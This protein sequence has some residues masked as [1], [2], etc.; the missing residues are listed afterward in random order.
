GE[1]THV[2]LS[3][4]AEGTY[5]TP[6]EE[7]WYPVDLATNSY[8]QGLA[9]TPLAMLTA[10]SSM[11][12]KGVLMRP[13]VVSKIVTKNDV[14][15]FEPVQVRQVVSPKTAETMM[16]LLHDVVDG[17]QFHG[18]Q[19]KGYEVAGKTGTTLVSIPTGYDLDSTIA[20][21]A[22]FIPAKDPKVSVLIKI[23]QPT[24]G[25]NL[26]GQVAAPI[27]ATVADQI[28]KYYAVPPAPPQ[29]NLVRAP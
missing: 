23:D 28:M 17:V 13:Y 5:R 14:R 20:S 8:G 15:T 29:K 9:T 21:F 10:V 22:G 4:E 2:G 18:A 1:S 7:G 11:A 26:G 25:L 16:G 27:F 19:V 24:G 12:N 3:G 6:K